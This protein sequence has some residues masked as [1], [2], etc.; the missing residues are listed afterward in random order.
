MRLQKNLLPICVLLIAGCTE[1][2]PSALATVDNDQQDPTTLEAESPNIVA[3]GKASLSGAQLDVIVQ[4]VMTE[5][6]GESYNSKHGCWDYAVDVSGDKTQYCMKP[7]ATEL[8]DTK[9]GKVLYFYA[10]NKSDITDD[11]SYQY[12]AVD[13]GLMGAFKLSI[14]ATANWK[15]L[16]INKAMD[17]GTMGSCGCGEAKFSRLGADDYGWMFTSGG[18]WQ[19]VMVSTHEIVAPQADSFKNISRIP[20]VREEHQDTKYTIKLVETD[21]NKK[22]FPL[23]VSKQKTGSAVES[24]TVEFDPTASVY[25]LPSNF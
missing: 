25:A 19:G 6:Y 12:S 20:E 22:M 2:A 13:S 7:M 9:S 17:F 1:K 24:L 23:L 4:K 11:A 5:Q 16:S 10:A 8:V 15:Y 18:M 3:G 14:D 21:A